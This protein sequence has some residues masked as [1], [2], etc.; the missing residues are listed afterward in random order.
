M[1]GTDEV[2]LEKGDAEGLS[3]LDF[4]DQIELIGLLYGQVAW[5]EEA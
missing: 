3:G 1:V 5:L 2:R 4:G